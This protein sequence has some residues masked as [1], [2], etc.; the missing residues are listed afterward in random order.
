LLNIVIK[1]KP[2]IPAIDTIN[3]IAIIGDVFLY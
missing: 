1:S 3:H 2:L